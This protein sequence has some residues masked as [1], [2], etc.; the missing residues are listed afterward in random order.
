MYTQG[1][2]PPTVEQNYQNEINKLIAQNKWLE[3][4]NL[5]LIRKLEEKEEADRLEDIKALTVFMKE[6]GAASFSF[7]QYH[8]SFGNSAI[9]EVL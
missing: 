8:V 6:Q 7:N 2:I 5:E 4:K 1:R 3:D 9:N